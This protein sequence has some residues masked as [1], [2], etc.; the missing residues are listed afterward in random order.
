MSPGVELT[1]PEVA[2]IFALMP[3]VLERYPELSEATVEE[4]FAVID[5]L[6]E[7]IRRL[8]EITVPDSHLAELNQRLAAVRADP[9]SALDP[10]EARRLLKR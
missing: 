4:K 3:H 5:E 6:W 1:K 2:D 9:S 8:G 7:S 10:A